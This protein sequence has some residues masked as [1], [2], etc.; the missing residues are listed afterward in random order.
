MLEDTNSLDAAQILIAILFDVSC[1]NVDVE[2]FDTA[3]D[4]HLSRQ[5]LS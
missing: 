5:Q 1:H 4:Y 3:A 2:C